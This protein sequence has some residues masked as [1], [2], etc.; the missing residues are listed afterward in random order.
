MEQAGGPFNV[1]SFQTVSDLDGAGGTDDL[2]LNYNLN[3]IRMSEAG[4][5]GRTEIHSN[6]RMELPQL[7]AAKGTGCTP[8]WCRWATTFSARL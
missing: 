4:S 5:A 6:C 8:D 1:Y 7:W 3:G 2:V